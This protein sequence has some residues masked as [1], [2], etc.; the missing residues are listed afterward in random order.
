MG[1]RSTLLLSKTYFSPL[2]KIRTAHRTELPP[3]LTE[4]Q[5]WGGASGGQH[6]S[7]ART[8]QSLGPLPP[9]RSA[10]PICFLPCRTPATFLSRSIFAPSPGRPH[11][12]TPTEGITSPT[13]TNLSSPLLP[14]HP[15]PQGTPS[16]ARFF[17]NPQPTNCALSGFTSPQCAPPSPRWRPNSA[18]LHPFPSIQLAPAARGSRPAKDCKRR[19]HPCRALRGAG[20]RVTPPPSGGRRSLLCAPRLGGAASARL[21]STPLG[22]ARLRSGCSFCGGGRLG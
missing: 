16:P 21:S 17:R 5:S 11:L 19:P 8:P 2:P 13:Q 6:R 14:F 10:Y 7:T 20:T 12:L 22:S 9:A 1:K 18:E 4:A 15:R 3:W